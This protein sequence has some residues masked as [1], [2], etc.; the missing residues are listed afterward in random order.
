MNS[1]HSVRK[2][3]HGTE[4]VSSDRCIFECDTC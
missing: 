3:F 4:D 1:M 2:M